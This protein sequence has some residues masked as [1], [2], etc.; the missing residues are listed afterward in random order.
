[1]YRLPGRRSQPAKS[2]RSVM[3]AFR[4][5]ET[6][7]GRPRSRRT[8]RLRTR[9]LR[10]IYRMFRRI[11]SKRANFSECCV[12]TLRSNCKCHTYSQIPLRP[13]LEKGSKWEKWSG[14]LDSNQRPPAPEAGALPDCATP[15]T[16]VSS[17]GK[18]RDESHCQLAGS[19][20]IR[21]HKCNR[22][23]LHHRVQ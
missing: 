6:R 3:A 17:A 22:K 12:R 23:S 20:R 16:V 4:S 15:R 10:P 9:E 19:P 18:L 5:E 2:L 8:T 1:M 11:R 7:P 21:L 13:P 14:R